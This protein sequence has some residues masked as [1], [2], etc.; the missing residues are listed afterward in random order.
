M[1]SKADYLKNFSQTD[2]DTLRDRLIGDELTTEA[3][4]AIRDILTQRGY[5]LPDIRTVPITDDE[6]RAHAVAIRNG[7]CPH[8]K[9]KQ[10][11]VEVR[12][13]HWVWSALI[14]TRYGRR[15][16][17]ACRDCGRSASLKALASSMVL[18]WWGVPFGLLVTPYK[19]VA[20]VAEL[21]RQDKPE[22]SPALQTFVR[23]RLA[24]PVHH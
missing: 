11:V 10:S 21:L 12:T 23:T 24:Q 14:L 6:V 3:K 7:A 19:I 1:Y 18:G 8:C 9:G 17:L 13:A 16:I 15:T 20:N 22:P 4:E 2:S 5:P